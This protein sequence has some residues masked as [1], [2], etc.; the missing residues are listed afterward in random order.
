MKESIVN[1]QEKKGF[2]VNQIYI[3]ALFSIIALK[4]IS[5]PVKCMD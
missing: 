1:M 4:G 2:L 5:M 3:V